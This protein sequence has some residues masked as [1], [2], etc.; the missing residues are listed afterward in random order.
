MDLIT[1]SVKTIEKMI[2]NC[3]C[4]EGDILLETSPDTV[5]CQYERGAC[6][7]ATFGGK[8]A[9]FVTDDPVRAMTKLSFMFDAP[10]DTPV[11]RSAAGSVIN[12]LAGFFSL[13]RVHHACQAPSH[14]PCL[15]LL[16]REL[17]GRQVACI[18]SMPTIES[19]F[20]NYFVQDPEKADV[21]LINGEGI[22]DPKAGAMIERYHDTKH[23]ICI[24]PS[25]SGIARLNALEHW[26][27]YGN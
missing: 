5:I 15:E 17:A 25:T 3:G 7:V 11:T 20:R 16:S 13:T 23:I 27:P 1:D 19:E 4:E 21:I 24:G 18:G 12:V 6:M 9:E 8:T 14:M 22:I 10:L 26:C 2:E